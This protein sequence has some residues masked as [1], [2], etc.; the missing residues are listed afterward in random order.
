M[1]KVRNMEPGRS[2]I[3]AALGQAV[4]G[5]SAQKIRLDDVSKSFQAAGGS[6]EALRDISLDIADGEFV[7]ILGESGCGKTTLLRIVAGLS[8]PSRGVVV[9]DGTPVLAPRRDL[10]FVFQQS[11][12]LEWRTVLDN[13]LLP[14]EIHGLSR[15]AYEE[16]ARSLL[17]FVGLEDFETYYPVQLSGGMQQRV[18]I[19]RALILKPAVLLMDEPFGALDAIT[20]EQLN[21]ELLKIWRHHRNTSVFVTHD[22][23]EAVFLSDRVVLLSPRPGTLQAVYPVDLPR[24]RLL[25]HRYDEDFVRICREI[26]GAMG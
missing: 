8:P 1:A 21:L 5:G 26:K 14:V 4:A 20:R 18:S 7:S 17:R 13:V 15:K 2:T 6:L 25:D 3:E 19:V 11:V 12:L 10:G 9:V 23:A 24:P 16:E 22:I